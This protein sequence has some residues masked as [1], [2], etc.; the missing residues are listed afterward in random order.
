MRIAKGQY[1]ILPA[2]TGLDPFPLGD[3]FVLACQSFPNGFIAY[4]SAAEHHGLS[5]Q[6]FNSVLIATP[7]HS[8]MKE[9]GNISIQ[10]VKVNKGN[11]VG[12]ESLNRGPG[13]KVATVERTIIDCIDRPDLAGGISDLIEILHRGKSR[14]RI[15]SV[16]ALLPSYASKSLSKKVGFLFEQFEYPMTEAQM[17][18]LLEIS[19]GVKAYLVSSKLPGSTE[20]KHYSK[21]WQLII[22]APGFL[23]KR[24]DEETSA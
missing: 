9:L 3:K 23:R 21:K 20:R 17:S 6:V 14:V 2:R 1:Q 11:Y 12:Y 16:I 7:D 22:N 5:L 10:L 4:G 24:T 15:D 18:E 13:V 8:G 19:R